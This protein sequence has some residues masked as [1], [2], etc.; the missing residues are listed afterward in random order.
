MWFP[1]ILQKENY[2]KTKRKKK[3]V[4]FSLLSF[5][6]LDRFLSFLLRSHT[7]SSIQKKYYISISGISDPKPKPTRKGKIWKG[8]KLLEFLFRIELFLS[9]GI[10]IRIFFCLKCLH[11]I[12]LI[13]TFW[14]RMFEYFFKIYS[15]IFLLVWCLSMDFFCNGWVWIFFY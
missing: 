8:E 12:C 15:S 4:S 7:V 11:F 5:L 2:C 3:G 1:H 14:I 13:A 6:S 9:F 10:R